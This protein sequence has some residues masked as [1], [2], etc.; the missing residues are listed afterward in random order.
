MAEGRSVAAGTIQKQQTSTKLLKMVCYFVIEGTF[1]FNTAC[2]RKR[3]QSAR[4]NG[5]LA[6][7]RKLSA[8]NQPYIRIWKNSEVKPH[9]RVRVHSRS[10]F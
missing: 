7:Q 10:S 6:E 4:F 1:S 5:I 9:R 8:M 2:G 3:E